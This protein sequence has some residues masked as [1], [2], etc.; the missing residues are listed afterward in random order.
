MLNTMSHDQQTSNVLPN[1]VVSFLFQ[2]LHLFRRALIHSLHPR[3]RSAFSANPNMERSVLFDLVDCLA[4]SRTGG[5]VITVPKRK[6][7][8]CAFPTGHFPHGIRQE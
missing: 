4:H 3:K 1:A 6:T 5:K 7:F 8:S 2:V